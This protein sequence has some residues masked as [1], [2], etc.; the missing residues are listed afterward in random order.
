MVARLW[1]VFILLSLLV[2]TFQASLSLA[3]NGLYFG[4]L[5]IVITNSGGYL[6]T[7]EINFLF[8]FTILGSII[9]YFLGLTDYGFLPGQADATS[10]HSSMSFRVSLFAVLSES[11]AFSLFVLLWN[12]FQPP[13]YVRG[14]RWVFIVI[15]LYFLLFSGIRSALLAFLVISPVILFFLFSI[16]NLLL[17]SVISILIPLCLVVFSVQL[18][19]KK[20]GESLIGDGLS[21]LLLRT[22][23]CTALISSGQESEPPKNGEFANN[24]LKDRAV[25]MSWLDQTINRHCSAKYQLRLFWESPWI[26]N[27]VVRPPQTATPEEVGCTSE[28]MERFC[29][30]CVLST[31]WLSRGGSVGIFLIYIGMAMLVFG[32]WRKNILVVV[33]LVAFAIFMQAWGVMFKPYNF[34][35]YILVSL[36]PLIGAQ[37]SELGF[38]R[39]WKDNL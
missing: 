19:A 22:G 11:A 35:F 24:L 31:Y 37:R 13:Q 30:A 32:I 33:T 21:N 36:I 28:T 27:L 2:A 6:R 9:I 8:L 15:A 26:G 25:S 18:L 12:V 39:G 23:T 16:R 1:W 20:P 3:Y 38:Y 5:A 17:R 14:L 7:E 10:C 34:T 29:E 4:L